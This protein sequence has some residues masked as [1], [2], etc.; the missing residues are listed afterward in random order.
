MRFKNVFSIIGP[1]M[2]GPSSSHTAGA[3]RIGRVARQLLGVQPEKVRILLYGSFAE[4]YQGHGT[5]LAL[6]GGLLDYETDDPRIRNSFEEAKL[7]GVEVSFVPITGNCPHPN[8][9][10]LELWAGDEYTEVLGASIGGGNIVIHAMS[11]FD[12]QCT[13]EFPT[14]VIQHIDS[15]G[16]IA[17]IT[18]ILSVFGLNIGYMDVDRKRRNGEAMTVIELDTPI[19]K[20]V[21]DTISRLPNIVKV[22]VIDLTRRS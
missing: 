4:T 22:S 8:T 5:D 7:A 20:Q 17:Q 9:A 6:I 15:T 16:I 2:V 21:Q 1:A 18:N 11:G 13:G 19:T 12:V 3:I 14:L 10:K